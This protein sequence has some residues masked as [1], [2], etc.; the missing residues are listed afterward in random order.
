VAQLSEDILVQ[1]LAVPERLYHRHD[2]ADVAAMLASIAPQAAL[3]H[4]TLVPIQRRR[5]G[6]PFPAR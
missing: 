5:A 3:V 6:R 2:A 1:R 4:A